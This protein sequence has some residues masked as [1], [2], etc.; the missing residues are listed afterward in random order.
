MSLVRPS[1]ETRKRAELLA[2]L[3][4]VADELDGWQATVGTDKAMQR[5]WSQVEKIVAD[6]RP[7]VHRVQTE[8][9][10]SDVSASWLQL[11]AYVLDLH[12]VW[13]FFRDKLMLRR[14]EF[15]PYLLMA[16]EFTYACYEPARVSAAAAGHSAA[17]RRREPPLV[18]L[19]A[20]ASPFSLSRGGPAGA[21]AGPNE[22]ASPAARALI[23]ELPVPVIGVPWFQLRHLPDAMM[24]GH[25][26]G[27]LV[28]SDFVGLDAVEDIVEQAL[29]DSDPEDLATWRGWA[30]EAFADVY[31]TL[32]GGA[33]YAAALADFLLVRGAEE[34][35]DPWYP[36]PSTRMLLTEAVL[37]A[38]GCPAEA[39]RL[40]NQRIA[41]GNLPASDKAA[42]QARAVGEALA[43]SPYAAFGA[44]LLTVI[45]CRKQCQTGTQPNDLVSGWD[46]TTEDIRTLLAVTVEA[47][48]TDPERF[49]GTDRE[50]LAGT[51]VTSRILVRAKKIHQPGKRLS[52]DQ[53][54]TTPTI[55]EPTITDGD[56]IDTLYGLLTGTANSG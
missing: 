18:Y 5:H 34:P 25:E 49:A 33:G 15:E 31:G 7:L 14:L 19:S 48:A 52:R 47:F 54:T 36:P 4:S 29:D 1:T 26:V 21:Q 2:K 17:A 53:S 9:E 24:L 20:V 42:K 13:G 3:R 51:D 22:P 11:E 37:D 32:C 30:E 27:H 43:T 10:S 28:V 44:P 8:I 16:D 41:E 55:A 38:A 46:L 12:R 56:R 50:R 35:A 40:R 23:D 45:N 39:D 6:L